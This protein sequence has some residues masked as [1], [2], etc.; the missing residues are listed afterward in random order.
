MQ[1]GALKICALYKQTNK[2]NEFKFPT[3][4]SALSHVELKEV[5][6]RVSK[7][8]QSKSSAQGHE[9]H[10]NYKYTPDQ[11]AMIGRYA[12]ENGPTRAAN[13]FTKILKMKVPKPTARRLKKEY[14]VRLNEVYTDQKQSLSMSANTSESNQII[15]KLPTKA[16]GRPLLL[17]I[18]L[19]QAVQDY[20]M[21]LR[22]VGGSVNFVFVL[23]AANC[24]KRQKLA[25][26]TWCSP[27]IDQ[28]MGK[29]FLRTNGVCEKEM[30]QCW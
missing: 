29:V 4:V 7:V 17:R 14:L 8:M 26:E 24:C 11:R 22:K 30:F 6:S 19:D 23:A 5:N 12:A 16:Q 28:G 20:I 13:H 2:E 15:K 25:Y 27:G 9:D 1:N 10:V 3:T 18:K 21:N